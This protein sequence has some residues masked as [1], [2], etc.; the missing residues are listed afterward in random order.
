MIQLKDR[1]K[2]CHLVK[3]CALQ[4]IYNATHNNAAISPQFSRFH[5]SLFS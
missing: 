4:Y 2:N 1:W 3:F 5:E